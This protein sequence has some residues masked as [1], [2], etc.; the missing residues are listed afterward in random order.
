MKGFHVSI[1]GAGLGGLCLA[2]GLQRAGIAFDVYER[3]AAPDSRPQ[4]YR[5]RI[6][7]DGQ[8][9]LSACLPPGLDLLFRQSCAV[10]ASADRF[11]DSAM[12]PTPGRPARN[13]SPSA[14]DGGMDG[15]RGDLSANRQ[16]LR[17][18]LLCGIERRVHF[19]KAYGRHVAMANGGLRVDFED[20][21]S[22]ATSLLVGAD[23]VNSQVRRRLAPGAEPVDTGAVCL[24]GK[25]IATGEVRQEVGDALCDGTSVIFADGF[26]AI[27]DAMRFR[28]ALPS[29]ATRLAPGCRLSAVDD[30][31]YWALIG[32]GSRLGL[33]ASTALAPARLAAHVAEL[34][35]DWHPRLQA[36]FATATRAASPCCRCAARACRHRGRWVW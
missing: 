27:L 16:T 1:V 6:D 15:G 14:Q 30:Y 20:G 36:D 35:Q 4:G 2:Q 17:E 18:I 32:P 24:Y 29:L 5:I 19:G 8:R 25:T 9:A 7:A 3:D 21:S 22:A 31:L 34:V 28:A 13:W 10:A 11:L 23:G 12:V 33:N 26:A